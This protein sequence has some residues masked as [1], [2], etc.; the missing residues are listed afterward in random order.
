MV[1]RGSGRSCSDSVICASIETDACAGERLYKGT[2]G[3]EWFAHFFRLD[4]STGYA[5]AARRVV[6]GTSII[7][8]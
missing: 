2:S 4:D 6:A 5:A 3:G 7:A 1:K 8:N